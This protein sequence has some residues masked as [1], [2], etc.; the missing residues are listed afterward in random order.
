MLGADRHRP[1]VE[2]E[3]APRELVVDGIHL[4]DAPAPTKDSM[5]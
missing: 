5:T 4:P 1:R 2:G 3:A